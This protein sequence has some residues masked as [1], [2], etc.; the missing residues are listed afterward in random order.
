VYPR[1][2]IMGPFHDIDPSNATP[3][4][5]GRKMEYIIVGTAPCRKFVLNFYT[6]P[7]YVCAAQLVTQQIVLYEGTGIIDIFLK[8]K[9]F[10][11]GASTNNGRAILGI[12]NWNQD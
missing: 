8:D 6:I 9:P 4:Q 3:Q 12:Q 2:T 7:Y 1:A 11:C 5:P 10:A